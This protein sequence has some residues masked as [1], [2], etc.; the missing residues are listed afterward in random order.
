VSASASRMYWASQ[1]IPFVVP[2]RREKLPAHGASFT[3]P[4]RCIERRTQLLRHALTPFSHVWRKRSCPRESAGRIEQE[5]S[6][7]LSSVGQE[8]DGLRPGPPL[9]FSLRFCVEPPSCRP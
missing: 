9:R 3:Q 1:R 4:Q 8:D 6:G 2:A 5:G 7:S